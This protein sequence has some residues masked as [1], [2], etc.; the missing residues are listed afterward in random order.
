MTP[1]T[2]AALLE[3]RL[4]VIEH[5]IAQV[6]EGAL[7]EPS[8]HALRDVLI[9]ILD[10]TE[11]NPGIEKAADDVYEGA[12]TV[13]SASATGS[14]ADARQ[15]RL[16]GEAMRRLRENLASAQPRRRRG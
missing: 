9:E 6:E 10:Q 12:L 5:V 14:R 8:L 15:L 1:R 11:R 3:E 4:S 16:L 2:F 7:V 13:A